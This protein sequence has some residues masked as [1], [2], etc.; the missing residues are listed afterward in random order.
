MAPLIS[1]VICGITC[2][3]EPRYSPRLRSRRCTWSSSRAHLS[4]VSSDLRFGPLQIGRRIDAWRCRSVEQRHTHRDAMQQRPELLETL[5]LLFGDG[6]EPHPRLQRFPRIR[7]HAD[8]LV[9][10]DVALA[11]AI[12]WN[13][14]T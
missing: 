13:R 7:V 4:E 3:V 2:T 10:D 12:E 1:S 14:R 5:P 8:V 6:G 9:V 11:I